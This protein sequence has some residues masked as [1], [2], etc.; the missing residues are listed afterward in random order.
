MPLKFTV[1]LPKWSIAIGKSKWY[2]R[3]SFHLSALP[4]ASR[5]HPDL[6]S[7]AQ[8]THSEVPPACDTL[9]VPWDGPILPLHW[10]NLPELFTVP[11][12]TRVPPCTLLFCLHC[13]FS[14]SKSSHPLSTLGDL[15]SL[16]KVL[17]LQSLLWLPRVKQNT[18]PWL[19]IVPWR[20]LDSHS[21]H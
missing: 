3:G 10:S 17:S 7:A 21:L 5:M 19:D 9:L 6:L 1:Y 16:I 2:Q 14:P 4:P 8:C 13:F 12:R 20:C 15:H 11:P 18:F